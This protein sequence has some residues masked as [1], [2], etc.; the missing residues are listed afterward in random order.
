MKV[1]KRITPEVRAKIDQYIKEGIDISELIKDYD[2]RGQNFAGAVIKKIS[3]PKEDL[4]NI[5]FVR[6]VIGDESTTTDFT[7]ANLMGSNFQWAK[8]IGPVWFRNCDLRNCNFNCAWM[9]TVEYQFADLRN[10]TLCDA[11]IRLGSRSGYQ[12]KLEWK[13]FELLA[14]YL[15]IEMQ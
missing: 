3:R 12:A 11:F 8:F 6:C 2:L 7:G 14:K 9:P 15:Q 10:V 4:R 13:A 5:N 1:R